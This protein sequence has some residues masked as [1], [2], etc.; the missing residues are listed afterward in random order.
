MTLSACGL[1]CDKCEVYN[2]SCFGCHSVKGSPDWAKEMMPSG[3]CPLY[4][5]TVNTKGYKN[6]GGCSELPCRLFLEMKDPNVSE[7]EH[8]SSIAERVERLHSD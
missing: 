4:D 6:C 1:I 8:L 7:E 3:I 5:C 2:I